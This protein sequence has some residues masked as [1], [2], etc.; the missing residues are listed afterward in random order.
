MSPW[1]VSARLSSEGEILLIIVAF[2][3]LHFVSIIREKF[4]S[5]PSHSFSYFM[6]I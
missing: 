6:C 5:Y 2:K 4:S 1:A 3:A